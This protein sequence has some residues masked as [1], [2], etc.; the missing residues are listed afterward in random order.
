I[1]VS[2][3]I[4]GLPTVAGL[5]GALAATLAEAF[6]GKIDDNFTVPVISGLVMLLVMHWLGYEEAVFFGAFGG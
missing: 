5:A 6:S 4:P 1:L 2:F 3:L